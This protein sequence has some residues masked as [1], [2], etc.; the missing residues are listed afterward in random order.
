MNHPHGVLPGLGQLAAQLADVAAQTAGTAAGAATA[1]VGK[2]VI[3]ALYD[4]LG[5]YPRENVLPYGYAC[6]NTITQGNAVT[7]LATV[8]NSIKISADAAFIATKITGTSTGDYLVTI[9][10]AGSDRVLMNQ[11]IHSAALVGT[12][13]RPSILAKPLLIQANSTVNM[14]YTDLSNA[15]NEIYFT[16][17]G[18]KVYNWQNYG[19]TS[20]VGQSQG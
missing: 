13:E 10:M 11:A 6:S 19:P 9:R 8:E 2:E 3:K 17:L 4:I 20:T 14:S 5:A 16:F 18:F 7:A 15:T 12:A 1:G